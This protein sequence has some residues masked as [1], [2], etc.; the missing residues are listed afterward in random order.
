MD[1]RSDL[2]LKQRE[3]CVN[4]V[5]TK[6]AEKAALLA[7]YSQKQV[8]RESQR[9]LKMPKIAAEIAQ[10]E[11][12]QAVRFEL[13]AEPILREQAALAF[14]SVE[15]F[16]VIEPDQDVSIDLSKATP[17]QLKTL[18]SVKTTTNERLDKDGEVIGRTTRVEVTLWDKQKAL[19]TLMRH[20]GMFAAENE[21]KGAAYSEALVDAVKQLHRSGSKTPIRTINGTA[22][23]LP[24]EPEGD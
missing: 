20:L 23:V 11:A 17:E 14:A 21:Q 24:D 7:G 6:D 5:A 1:R 8:C 10:M 16:L 2:T 15:P 18:K 4:Y 12:R 22:T 3:F 19:E 9:L 13:E